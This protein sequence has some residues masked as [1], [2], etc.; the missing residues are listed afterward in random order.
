MTDQ[1][2]V[3]HGVEILQQ[4]PRCAGHLLQPAGGRHFNERGTRIAGKPIKRIDAMPQRPGDLNMY[5]STAVAST[6]AST[7]PSPPSASGNFR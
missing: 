4:D 6:I 2:A 1:L 5:D 3:P 7:V